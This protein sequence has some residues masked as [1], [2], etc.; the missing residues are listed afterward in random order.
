MGRRTRRHLVLWLAA[1]L[2][3]TAASCSG[4]S[5]HPQTTTPPQPTPPKT[6]FD[7]SS[8]RGRTVLLVTHP[9]RDVI[10]DLATLRSK[11][12][13]SAP[14]LFVLGVTH[15]GEVER[16]GDVRRLI[17]KRRLDWVGLERLTCALDDA[18]VFRENACSGRLRELIDASAGLLVPGGPDL[19]P[20]LYGQPTSL[21]TTFRSPARHRL[22]A[23]LLF[24][25]VGG[26]RDPS[27]VPMLAKRPT[28][29]VLAL[30]LGMHT[31]DVVA[32]G[33][34]V[35]DIPSEL[36][37]AR[38]YEDVAA[39]PAD[40]RHYNPASRLHPGRSI[41]RGV[42][43]PIVPEGRPALWDRLDPDGGPIAVL[44]N[45][46]QAIGELGR[47]LEVLARSSDGRIIEA[48][49]HRRFPNVL[50]LQFHPEARALYD[51]SRRARPGPK[52][53]VRNRYASTL[54]N[55]PRAL[56]FHTE[57]WRMFREQLEAGA[58]R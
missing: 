3:L 35:Q 46:H 7:L 44:S 12:L 32:G 56:R 30:C 58:P 17:R 49:G 23:T 47:D 38:T 1:L 8:L 22:Q 37:G 48:V 40:R 13:L 42:F 51:P 26:A 45:H 52:S 2:A 14:G 50:G 4:G 10:N 53:S 21:L 55:D 11:G 33:S 34:L 15:A 27:F 16:Y 18:D 54:G 57:L 41:A 28:Y 36:Y 20:A 24:H 5:D 39:L 43:H 6:A 29:P 31:L 9:S 25:L 19:P